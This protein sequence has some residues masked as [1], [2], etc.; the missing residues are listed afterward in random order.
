MFVHTKRVLLICGTLLFS[1]A[2][3]AQDFASLFLEANKTDTTLTRVT[4]SPKMMG[5]IIKSDTGKNEDIIEII[6]GLKSMQILSS[7]EQ[8]EAYYKKALKIIEKNPK[9]F[10][11]FI[12]Y[13]DG[14][15]N[16]RIMVR[17]KGNAI[18]ELI[19]LVAEENHFALI[20]L[21]GEIKPEFISTLT[22][23]IT[24]KHS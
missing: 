23:S 15:E 8:G 18:I 16:Y 6:S 9:R 20:N 11:P 5:E 3:S 10:Q 7:N 22:K 12:S 21:T 19:M 17:K 24:Q 2:V 14:G 4:I 1:L 13:E